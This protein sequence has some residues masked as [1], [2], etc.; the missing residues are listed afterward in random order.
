M[1]RRL[2]AALAGGLLAAAPDTRPAGRALVR[3]RRIV[4]AITLV[5]GAVLLALSLGVDP[6]DGAFYPLSVATALVWLIGGVLS[7]PLRLGRVRDRHPVILPIL[8]GLVAAGVFVLGAVIVREIG[9][10]A[11]QVQDVL[12]FARQGN[13]PIVLAVTAV[14]GVG[15]EVFFR[16]AVY[17]SAR[18]FHPVAVSAALYTLTTVATLNVMLV[19]A[20]ALLSIIW[21]LQ[22]RASAG[23]LA[24]ILTHVTW[25]V[26]MALVLPP[27]FS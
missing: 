16:G 20:G 19:F 17:S 18:G 3:R 4:V 7:G 15:E 5:L 1:T 8:F 25:S 9:P 24:P 21:G 23:V 22:R 26:T 27:L 6:G 2:A 13:L 12:E 11:N 10:L 14:S